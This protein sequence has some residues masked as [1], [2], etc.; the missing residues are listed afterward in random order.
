MHYLKMEN[1]TKSEERIGRT[2]NN[3][4]TEKKL[5]ENDY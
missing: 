2:N 4:E 3:D 5:G 1:K